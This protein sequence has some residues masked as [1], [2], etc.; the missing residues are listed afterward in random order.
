MRIPD[1][2]NML[3]TLRREPVE[4]PVLYEFYIDWDPIRETLGD[5]MEKPDD[6]PFGWLR[7]CVAAHVE[8][9]YDAFS[10]G[11]PGFDFNFRHGKKTETISQNEG[12][13]IFDEESFENY[14]WPDPDTMGVKTVDSV[15]AFL[16]VAQSCCPPGMKMML[17]C[18]G[19]ME[20]LVNLAGFDNVCLMMFENP[21]L[22]EKICREVGARTNRLF[23]I[24]MGHPVVGA[25]VIA[26]DWGFKSSTMFSPEF[27]RRHIF[28]WHKKCVATIHNAGKPAVLHACGQVADVMEDVIEDMKYDAKHSFEDVILPV[29]EAYEKWG[30]RIAILGGFDVQFMSLATPEEIYRRA[31]A[32]LRQ[33]R[34]RGGY[35]LG[36]GNSV[37][38]YTPMDNYRAMLKAAHEGYEP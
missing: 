31:R 13:V 19:I 23:E 32:V 8:L 2:N 33:T 27:L 29:E 25:G 15:A 30:R 6:P 11:V 26:D 36:T 4:R 10:M 37:T 1:F 18:G 7:N 35:A 24:C 17:G 5:R 28:P 34:E 16:D 14:P 38:N 22:V 12:G 20:A 9:G 3:K 21:G